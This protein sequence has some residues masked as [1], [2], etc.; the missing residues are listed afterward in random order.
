M[1]SLKHLNKYLFKYKYLL[2]LG[3]VFFG[4]SNVFG[5]YPAQIIRQAFDLA[6]AEI[7]GTEYTSES[8][9]TPFFEGLSFG[10]VILLFGGIV[11]GLALMK[12]VFVF[13]MRQTIIIMSRR[14]EFDLKNEIYQHPPRG[15]RVPGGL[16]PFA[17]PRR[18][19]T[20]RLCSGPR[21]ADG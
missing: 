10:M 2:I 4:I 12:G 18:A 7:N 5:L 8:F 16:W 3:F 17:G 6:D 15:E 9:L 20:D 19:G 14:A 21:R 1:K 11:L 13:L